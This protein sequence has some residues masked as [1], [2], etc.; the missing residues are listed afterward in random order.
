MRRYIRS[1]QALV[2]AVALLAAACGGGGGGGGIQPPPPLPDFV[3]GLSPGTVS[4]TQGSASSP[5]TISV[6]P[7]NGFSDSVQVTFKNLPAGVTTNPAAPFSVPAGQS[8]SVLFGA[9][10]DTLAGQFNATAQGASGSLTHL[11]AF[12]LA[13]HAVSPANLPRTTYVENDSLALLDSPQGEPR[14]RHLVYDSAN[15]KFYVANCAMNRV[16]VYAAGS[17]ALQTTLDAAGAASVDLSPD[18][19]T[20]WIATG[21]EEILAAGTA[22]LQVKVRYPSPVSLPFP[23]WSSCGQRRCWLFPAE[24]FSYVCGRL[25]RARPSSLRGI[26]VRILS[27]TSRL[28]RHRYSKTVSELSRVPVTARARLSLRTIPAAK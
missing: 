17:P 21:L 23:G 16:E 22:T 2:F 25:V 14:R 15:Q 11:E 12:S 7:Q 10:S 8:V 28:W 18:G 26:P 4:L 24:S 13:I 20:L 19:K 6:T 9:S 27:P 5:A 1:V 3:L